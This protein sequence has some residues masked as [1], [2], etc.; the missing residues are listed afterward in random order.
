MP[1]PARQMEPLRYQP[2]MPHCLT[3]EPIPLPE[4]YQSCDWAQDLVIEWEMSAELEAVGAW[5]TS[6][7]L[8]SGPSG[9]GKTTSAR[10]IAQQLKLPVFSMELS[11][12]IGSYL[13]ETGKHIGEALRYGARVPGVLVLDELDAI[14]IHRTGRDDIG[15]MW[16]VT[17]TLLQTLDYWHAAPRP[18]LLVATTNL[19]DTIDGAIRRR[20]ELEKVLDLPTR[21]ELSRIAGVEI[22]SDCRLTQ[23]ELRRA[24]LQ[25]RRAMVLRGVDYRQALMRI[26]GE[27]IN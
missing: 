18:S 16:R 1:R 19:V 23:A 8:L 17:N 12:V 13:G 3:S 7:L 20:F 9:V 2:S 5:P 26:I 22:P 27:I 25:A 21:D 11:R 4:N 15:E 6:S 14:A 24:V 10:W